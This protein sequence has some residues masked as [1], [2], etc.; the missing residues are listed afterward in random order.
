[1]KVILNNY[2]NTVVECNNCKSLILIE[3]DEELITDRCV[4]HTRISKCP[5]CH[6][7]NVIVTLINN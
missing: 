5:C 4:S 7:E 2:R 6:E 3:N 1:M